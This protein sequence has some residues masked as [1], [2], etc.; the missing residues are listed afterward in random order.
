MTGEI[1]TL[2]DLEEG[3]VGY[4]LHLIK[5]VQY[6]NDERLYVILSVNIF[7]FELDILLENGIAIDLNFTF[8]VI[9]LNFH[10]NR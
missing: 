2:V 4:F 1:D 10:N 9:D 3:I 7:L 6:L 5:K 8:Y